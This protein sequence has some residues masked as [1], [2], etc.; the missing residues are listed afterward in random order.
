MFAIWAQFKSATRINDALTIIRIVGTLYIL[1]PTPPID[2]MVIAVSSLEGAALNMAITK[3]I[4]K[5]LNYS[6][7][8]NVNDDKIVR[9]YIR[10]LNGNMRASISDLRDLLK[11][12][13]DM[14]KWNLLDL[15]LEKIDDF[16]SLLRTSLTGNAVEKL[17]TIHNIKGSNLENLLTQDLKIIDSM[18]IVEA[19]TQ[20][21]FAD[22]QEQNDFGGNCLAI[23]SSMSKC[24]GLY[25]ERRS[26]INGIPLSIINGTVNKKS[27]MKNVTTVVIIILTTCGLF[28]YRNGV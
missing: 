13:N 2:T 15:T 21:L 26:I 25:K 11:H 10:T 12:V 9:E 20:R 4:P 1:S 28:L 22:G 8:S 27:K 18:K 24:I 3:V 16:D 7:N 17:Q 19:M 6:P 23:N 5:F 14:E